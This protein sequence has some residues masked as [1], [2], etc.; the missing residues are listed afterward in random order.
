MK[1]RSSARIF[2]WSLARATLLPILGMGMLMAMVT[3]PQTL[4]AQHPDV[5]TIQA[6]QPD[7]EGGN[8]V[9]GAN[10]KLAARFAPYLARGLTYSTSVAP[11]WIGQTDRFW[12][13]WE[14]ADGTSYYVVDP[15]RSSKRLI[16]DNDRIAAELTRITKDPF[17]GQ[18]LP[19]RNIQFIDENTIQFEVPSTVDEG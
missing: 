10:F 1:S 6:H 12:Y 19:I 3:V 9:W 13:Q 11:R 5:A 15:A 4:S 14:N 8:Q 18:H 16:F 7:V 17:D 2:G